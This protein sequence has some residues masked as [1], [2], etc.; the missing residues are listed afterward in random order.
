MLRDDFRIDRARAGF[1]RELA[2]Q[3]WLCGAARSQPQLA[4]AVLSV[5]AVVAKLSQPGGNAS[6][7][8]NPARYFA[9][10][11]PTMSFLI[12][13]NRYVVLDGAADGAVVNSPTA[14]HPE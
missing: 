1:F 10:T 9:Q 6:A 11:N 14:A 4:A 13:T 12:N 5:F 2:L 8:C 3:K 7:P